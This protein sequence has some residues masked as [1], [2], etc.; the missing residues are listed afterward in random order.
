ML[1]AH[2][3]KRTPSTLLLHM[4]DC[5]LQFYPRGGGGGVSGSTKIRLKKFS[6]YFAV[7]N[8]RNEN[9][10]LLDCAVTVAGSLT[11]KQG[12][13]KRGNI[14]MLLFVTEAAGRG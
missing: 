1:F 4:H 2:P 6:T 7:E 13:N 12:F 8:T 10:D 3:F 5:S 9:D 11:W 14:M